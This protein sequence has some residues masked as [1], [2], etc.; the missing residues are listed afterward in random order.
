MTK[1][2]NCFERV[3]GDKVTYD[4]AEVTFRQKREAL[5]KSRATVWDT[6]GPPPVRSL[7]GMR[8]HYVLIACAFAI[9][10]VAA[11]FVAQVATLLGFLAIA[12]VVMLGAQRA[13]N[14]D[15]FQQFGQYRK[16]A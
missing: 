11:S 6:L 4:K 10:L 1:T 12:I 3:S 5:Q 8:P 15:F 2:P 7:L 16:R 14:I 13:F 9:A